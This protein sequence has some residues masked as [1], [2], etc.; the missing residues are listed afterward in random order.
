MRQ[1]AIQR[2]V[3][4]NRCGGTCGTCPSGTVCSFTQARCID[5]ASQKPLGAACAQNAFCKPYTIDPLN[6]NNIYAN[7]NWPGCLHDQCRDGD[8]INGFCSRTCTVSQ[9]VRKT[10]LR[11]HFRR[12]RRRPHTW[13]LF[14]GENGPYG[15][16]FICVQSSGD[17]L[18]HAA[19]V[20]LPLSSFSRCTSSAQC[21]I[22]ESCGYIR[23]ATTLRP[24]V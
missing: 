4:L 12:H 10:V 16:Q 23:F 7:S 3:G 22:K 5:Q 9:D 18:I 19:R 2:S 21:D 11:F 14:G 1:I 8:C 20:C 24:D 15:D 13:R 6:P 17:E